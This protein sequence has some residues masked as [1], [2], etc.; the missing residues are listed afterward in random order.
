MYNWCGIVLKTVALKLFSLPRH[1]V[2]HAPTHLK[3]ASPDPWCASGC[4]ALIV[5]SAV[6]KGTPSTPQQAR[7]HTAHIMP[8]RNCGEPRSASRQWPAP[9]TPKANMHMGRRDC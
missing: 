9:Y 3:D 8:G 1:D 2:Y 4:T 6:E 5:P 7:K